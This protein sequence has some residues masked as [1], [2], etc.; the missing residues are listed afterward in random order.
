[1]V[2]LSEKH[3]E[4][5]VSRLSMIRLSKVQAPLARRDSTQVQIEMGLKTK[6]IRAA[7]A[8]RLLK[9]PALLLNPYQVS[10][11][12]YGLNLIRDTQELLSN[13]ADGAGPPAETSR[14]RRGRATPDRPCGGWRSC[15]PTP[16]GNS[17]RAGGRSLQSM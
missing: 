3:E 15:G 10:V 12:G 7:A 14:L 11:N 4:D 2:P 5:P 16:H 17:A 1:M 6:R 8:R 9:P 13:V